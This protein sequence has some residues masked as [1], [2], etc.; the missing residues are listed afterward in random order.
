MEDSST[1]PQ[2]RFEFRKS[3]EEDED[4]AV[5]MFKPKGHMAGKL[6]VKDCSAPGAWEALHEELLATDPYFSA[7]HLKRCRDYAWGDELKYLSLA[8]FGARPACGAG[9]S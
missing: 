8:A 4:A 1:P 7:L 3:A 2:S 6:G 9:A 5:Y